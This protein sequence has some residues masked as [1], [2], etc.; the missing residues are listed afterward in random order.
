[1]SLARCLLGML[2]IIWLAD[3]R[4]TMR[5]E[6]ITSSTARS[7][8]AGL[9]KLADK[10]VI[11]LAHFTNSTGIEALDGALEEVLRTALEE[12]PGQFDKAREAYEEMVRMKLDDDPPHVF[13]YSLGFLQHDEKRMAVEAAWFEGKPQ[14]K[15]EVLSEQADA[16]AYTGHLARARE[17][18]KQAV[19]AALR[20]DNKEQAAA[21]QLN[22]AWREEAFGNVKEA[23][24]QTS[25]TLEI[26]PDSREEGAIA[27]PSRSDRA[28]TQGKWHSSGSGTAIPCS[29]GRSVVLAAVYSSAD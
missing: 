12:S 9:R 26:A 10:D 1:M 13:M 3:Q 24:E 29:R 5:R 17:L 23:R 6:H 20:A 15:H 22:S 27:A 25:R 14:L 18:T 19:E 7:G 11:F 28:G 2:A 16:A 21:W 4:E 8:T